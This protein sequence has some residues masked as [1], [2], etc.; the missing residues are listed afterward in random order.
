MNHIFV[1]FKSVCAPWKDLKQ[2]QGKKTPWWRK[3]RFLG[4]LLWKKLLVFQR[5]QSSTKSWSTQICKSKSPPE[6][7]KVFKHQ[8]YLSYILIL[9][10]QRCVQI[11]KITYS[12]RDPE[13][14]CYSFSPGKSDTRFEIPVIKEKSCICL[15]C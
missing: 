3:M 10:C 13:M 11:Y 1:Q 7:A 12:W 9:L 5:H 6:G 14:L 8:D 15:M 4:V 2:T